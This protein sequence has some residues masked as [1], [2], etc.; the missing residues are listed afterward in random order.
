MSLRAQSLKDIFTFTR[1]STA[2]YWNS[3]GVLTTAGV[4]EP[5]VDHDPVTLAC[6]GL[7]LESQRTNLILNSATFA[8][9]NVT[10]TNVKHTLS[11]YGTGSIALTGT[12][13]A[14]PLSGTGASTRVSLVFT[15]TAGTLTLTL[16]GTASMAQLEIGG[17]A[18]SYIPTTSEAV[19][20]ERDACYIYNA[21]S[22]WFNEDEGTVF[23][24]YFLPWSDATD[25]TAR[26]IVEINDG[27]EANRHLC[28]YIQLGDQLAAITT[29]SVDQ[30]GINAGAAGANVVH[31][32]A[33]AWTDG[34]CAVYDSGGYVTS[35]S[36][37][38]IPT[39]LYILLLTSTGSEPNGYIRKVKF[40]P[41]RLSN[42]ELAALVA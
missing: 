24:E 1:A 42:A 11:F 13:T 30:I 25:S 23:V 4:D 36:V 9:Q 3:A 29:G 40:Y 7:L 39:G 22:P 37:G 6:R 26:R 5:R 10:V 14:G 12:S 17:H 15:P 34:T 2:T 27:T 41:R 20:R 19:T 35:G 38:S 18:T 16:T 8:T 21:L 32:H 33:Y 31:K 28:L